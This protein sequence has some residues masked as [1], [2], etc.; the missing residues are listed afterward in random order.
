MLC[1]SQEFMALQSCVLSLQIWVVCEVVVQALSLIM[2]GCVM[3]QS[4]GHWL[5]SNALQ[6]IISTCQ[7][8]QELLTSQTVPN[9]LVRRI[10][11]IMN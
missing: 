1:Y 6:F 11:F 8:V 5:L 7:D 3:N 10:F 4:C 2:S 9:T